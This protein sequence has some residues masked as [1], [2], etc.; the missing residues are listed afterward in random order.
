M[1]ANLQKPTK[2]KGIV[3]NV[4]TDNSQSP[5]R[6]LAE[7]AL[8]S[9]CQNAYT[10]RLFSNGLFGCDQSID[11]G[12]AIEILRDAECNAKGN[13]LSRLEGMLA[14]QSI[15][16]DSIFNSL[17]RRASLNLGSNLKVADTYL[18]L[19]LKAQSQCRTT[20]EALAEIKNPKSVA[21]V[22]QA[23]IAQGHQQ[24][25]NGIADSRSGASDFVNSPNEL[26]EQQH[27][28]RVDTRTKGTAIGIDPAMAT[29]ETIDRPKNRSRKSTVR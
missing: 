6:V 29:V 4:E 8:S 13:D 1:S 24:V 10:A 27:G 15:A 19:A 28:E 25:N 22:R 2:S 11:F 9:V 18:R 21:F 5:A 16:L 23:N 20:V 14:S 3:L 26:L 17:A 7:V 12:E